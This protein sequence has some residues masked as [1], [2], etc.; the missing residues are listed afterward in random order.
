[1]DADQELRR[2]DKAVP[3]MTSQER[4]GASRDGFTTSSTVRD[5][6]QG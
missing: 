5:L 3:P 6:N 4:V 2:L 1:M